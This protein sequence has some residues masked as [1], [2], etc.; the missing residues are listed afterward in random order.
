MW[1]VRLALERPYTFVVMA[2]AI[3]LLGGAAIVTMPVDI[4]PYIDIPIVSVVWSYSGISPEEMEKRIVTIFERAITTTVNDVEH[5][6]SQSYNGI[7]VI[8][9]F[10][11]PNAKVEMAIAQVTS[12]SGSVSRVMPP[13]IFPPGVIKYDASSVPILQLGLG[14]RTLSEQQLYDLGQNFI[15][16]QLA[17]VQGA[18]VPTPFGGKVR[19]VMVDLDPDALY[20]KQLSATDVSNAI[21]AQN[22]ILPAGT[23][24][25][26]DRDYQVKVNSSPRILDEL[27]NLPI[28]TVN[29]ATVYIRDVAQVR[30]GYSVQYNIVRTN[31]TRGAL[32]TILRNG[33]AST[34]EIVDKVKAALP[35]ILRSMPEGLEVRQMFDQS[36][37]V[38]A[39]ING[40]VR[41]AVMA[42]LLTGL[43]ILL[44]LGSWRSTVI[45]SLSIPLSILS[46]L[47]VL[48]LM[49]HTINVMTLGGM[50]LAVGILVDDATVAIENIHRN[51]ALGKPL[52][53]GVLDGAQ[54]IAVPAFVATL[55]I[56]IVFVPVLLL[57]GTAR[58][59][60]TPLALAVVFAMMAS[61][62]LSRTLVPT[63]A[64]AMLKAEIAFYRGEEHGKDLAVRLHTVVNRYFEALRRSYTGLLDWSLDHRPFLLG[65]AVVFTLASFVLLP[66]VGQDF[67]PT[68]DSGQ[69]RFHVRA[70]PGTRIEETERLFA[71][72]ENEVRAVIPAAELDTIVDN[73]GLPSSGINLAFGD[74]PNI[75]VGDGD[76]LVSLKPE[77]RGNTEVYSRTL[78]N[79]L[80]QKFP[81]ATFYWEA[82]NIT[83]QILNFGLPAPIDVQI[84]GRDTTRNY[85][86]AEEL[87]RRLARIPGAVDVH[88]HQVVDYPD[89]RLNVD[90]NV[91]GQMGLSQR[92]VANSLM[93]S[94]SSSGQTAP[95][96]WLNWETGVNYQVSVQTPQRRLNSLEALLRTPVAAAGASPAAGGGGLNPIASS[97]AA[98]AVPNRTSV[99]YGNPGAIPPNAQ[100][101][102]NMV[103]TTRGVA[104][105]IVNHYNAQPVFDV[106]AG[107]D[108]RDLGSVATE[109][110]RVMADVEKRLPKGS[111]MVLRGQADTMQTSFGR[112]AIGLIAAVVLVYLLM[113]VN[114]QSWLD[115]FIIL[116]P[117]PTAMAGIVWALFVTGTTLSVP[118]LMG[119][120][121]CIGVATANSIL[122]V[123]FAND[124]QT[125]GCSARQAALAAG[126]TRMRPVLMTAMAMIIGMVPMALG[127]GE[128][129][130]QNAPLGRAVIGGLL[131]ATVS[132]L[133]VVPVVYSYLR[134][135]PPVDHQRVL[136]AEEAES[137]GF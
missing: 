59:L 29:G 57:T 46:S 12:V 55:S 89:I 69:M 75:G 21:N 91:A 63:M 72:V 104:P 66:L 27:N 61:Y 71:A 97:V 2:L 38:K 108:R 84:V 118:S 130:E 78:R 32:L 56:C 7:S 19:Q 41:E 15:R 60:F 93:I 16:T 20:A 26:G 102:G 76:V 121:M 95:N 106:F 77:R 87:E 127:M 74:S 134:K 131:F 88:I 13:G 51:L 119:A 111:S 35:K 25:F 129:G 58:Y 81:D 42:A 11:Q 96:Q 54:Q 116:V 22:L 24:K 18:S 114:F 136:A 135:K 49:G 17:T 123:T 107:T 44:F 64:H 37:F 109:V 73:I 101:L 50:A 115:P 9:V 99:A 124:Q 3:V 133:F 47:I 113:V 90:R 92:D 67:F 6:E 31:G 14:S 68:V 83:N 36:I 98:S 70:A 80:R 110:R 33:K 62:I 1:V 45:V 82:A 100:M 125:E 48:N 132:T 4:F 79:R 5:I 40:V 23:A 53:R 8:R 28:R 112:L 117:L 128:G 10:F 86:V 137:T 105:Q 120:I 65:A 126:F 52:V 39:A 94:L 103:T 30:D 34:L 85:A 122:V 43:M